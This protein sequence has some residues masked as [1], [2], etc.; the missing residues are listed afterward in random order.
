MDLNDMQ[1]VGIDAIEV[2]RVQNVY[3]KFGNK[4]RSRI[5]TPNEIKLCRGRILELSA[6]FAGKEA[7]MK[8]LGTGAVG[9]SWK[10]IEILSNR[11][12]KPIINFY[13]KAKKR[14]EEIKLRGVDISITHL[15]SLAIVIVVGVSEKV[16]WHVAY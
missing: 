15:N 10:E 8:A 13:G 14:A 9:I 12:G 11:N 6:R 1:A 7:A 16:N 2:H 4:F 5:Y 3:N